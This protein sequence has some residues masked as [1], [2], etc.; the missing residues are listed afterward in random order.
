MLTA[1]VSCCHVIVLAWGIWPLGRWIIWHSLQVDNLCSFTVEGSSLVFL[2][3]V[4]LLLINWLASTILVRVDLLF[5]R[6]GLLDVIVIH[7]TVVSVSFESLF[8]VV[9][10]L[11]A[12]WGGWSLDSASC[13]HLITWI[14]RGLIRCRWPLLIWSQTLRDMIWSSSLF[15]GVSSFLTVVL[16]HDVLLFYIYL[17]GIPVQKDSFCIWLLHIS[18]LLRCCVGWGTA[19]RRCCAEHV[20]LVGH[21]DTTS[22]TTGCFRWNLVHHLEVQIYW[23]WLLG[24]S[25]K[26]RAWYTGYWVLPWSEVNLLLLYFH[27]VVLAYLRYALSCI[28]LDQFLLQLLVFVFDQLYKID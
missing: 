5:T 22:P 3:Q 17:L 8:L 6:L 25:M 23:V 7:C 21:C 11:L 12:V 20:L 14:F 16:D 13:D 4:N 19:K 24:L 15:R 27:H 10:S 2:Q 26:M 1:C 9:T 28:C 18:L